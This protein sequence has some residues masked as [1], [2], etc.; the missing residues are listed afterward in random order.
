LKVQFILKLFIDSTQGI[1]F[2]DCVMEANKAI[3]LMRNLNAAATS[4]WEAIN[5]T[6]SRKS[7]SI[8]CR[9]ELAAGKEM[10]VALVGREPTYDELEQALDW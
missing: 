6:H 1:C 2:N 3:S 8:C 10:F 5:V 4:H 7:V 9:K